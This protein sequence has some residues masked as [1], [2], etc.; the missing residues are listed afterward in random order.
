MPNVSAGLG[1]S[2]QATSLKENPFFLFQIGLN[3]QLDATK[4]YQSYCSQESPKTPGSGR[5][6]LCRQTDRHT[7][8][9]TYRMNR[10]RGRYAYGGY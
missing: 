7:D 10:H 2:G 1:Q 6:L 8:I 5:Q 9:A 4:G 3:N